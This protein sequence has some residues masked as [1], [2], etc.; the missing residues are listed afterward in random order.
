LAARKGKLP[1][2]IS[3]AAIGADSSDDDE[4]LTKKLAK[5]KASIEKKAEKEA[6][7]INAKVRPH[8]SRCDSFSL[9]QSWC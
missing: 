3:A 4:P 1:P 6:K 7:A 2:K 9:A 8:L 5:E